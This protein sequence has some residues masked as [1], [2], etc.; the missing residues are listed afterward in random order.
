MRKI[1][2]ISIL[3]QPILT[4]GW[5]K[6]GHQIVALIAQSQLDEKVK[7]KVDKYLFGMSYEDAG[8]WMDDIKRE[9][10]FDY[11]KPW[12]YVNI[13]KGAEYAKKDT[14]GDIYAEINASVELL[15]KYKSHS[16]EEVSKALKIL[17]HLCGDMVQPLHVGYGGDKGGNDVKL[18]Y[19][20]KSSNL[21]KVWDSEIIASENITYSKCYSALQKYSVNEISEIKKFTIA[22]WMKDSRK[23]LPKVYDMPD[24]KISEE[25]KTKNA[26]L[27]ESQLI[28]GGIR[29]A[30]LLNQV[31]KD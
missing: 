6:E 1:L 31:F 20:G 30:T 26:E 28:V 12:H 16:N 18:E 17:F 27:I 15:K 7:E 13:D 24:G 21:H 5:G 4:F 2:I 9:R 11:M 25:Y 22:S 29:L 10:A 3:L 8:T 14:T 19:F 23:L